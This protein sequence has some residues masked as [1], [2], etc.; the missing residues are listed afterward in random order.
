VKEWLSNKGYL[1]EG[2]LSTKFLLSLKNFTLIK[3]C[4][5]IGV[6]KRNDA[7]RRMG[8]GYL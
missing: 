6:W 7:E 8:K 3:K 1:N 5:R 2:G 4:D